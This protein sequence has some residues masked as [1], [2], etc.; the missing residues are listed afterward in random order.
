MHANSGRA[1]CRVSLICKDF[2]NHSKASYGQMLAF[3]QLF[4]SVCHR[5]SVIIFMAVQDCIHELK[6]TVC[7]KGL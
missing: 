3:V 7:E 4:H 6:D 5:K 1:S 2:T